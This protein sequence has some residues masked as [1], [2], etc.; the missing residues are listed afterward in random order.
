MRKLIAVAALSV[1]G[2]AHLISTTQLLNCGTQSVETQLPSLGAQVEAVLSGGA[3]NQQEALNTLF[4]V[5]GSAVIC[6]VEAEIQ[7][8]AASS[9]PAAQRASSLLTLQTFL[10][11]HNVVSG[12]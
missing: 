8:L 6:A 3:V 10:K 5:A 7:K 4:S 1:A 11:A 9:A 2:C 12:S